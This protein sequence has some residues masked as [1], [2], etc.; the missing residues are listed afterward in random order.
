MGSSREIG[1]QLTTHD[2]QVEQATAVKEFLLDK[3]INLELHTWMK[4]RIAGTFFQT[5]NLAYE[6]AKRAEKGA[7]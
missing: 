2:R 6:Q 5:Y 7:P 4:G 1:D 3:S